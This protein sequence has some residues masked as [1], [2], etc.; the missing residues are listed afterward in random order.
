MGLKMFVQQKYYKC[1]TFLNSWDIEL[2]DS[3]KICAKNSQIQ[4]FLRAYQKKVKFLLKMSHC[5]SPVK[6]PVESSAEA[7]ASAGD[8]TGEEGFWPPKMKK[9]VKIGLDP[10]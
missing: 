5:E 2:L 10:W 1:C 6:S 9:L 7:L 4:K 3:T 8:L